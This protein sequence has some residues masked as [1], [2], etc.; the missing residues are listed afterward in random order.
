MPILV[1]TYDLEPGMKLSEAIVADGRIMLQG[2]KP[3]TDGDIRALRRRYPGMRMRVGDPVLDELI[4]FEDDSRERAVADDAQR[5]VAKCMKEVHERFSDRA[6]LSNVQVGALQ[7][8]VRDV[9]DFIK[10]NPVSMALLSTC[11]EPGSYLHLHAGNVFYLSMLL[12]FRLLDY[13]MSERRR[14]TRAQLKSRH[15]MDLVPLGFGAMVMDVGLSEHQKLLASEHPLTSEQSAALRRHPDEGLKLL[16]ERISALTRMVV[17]SHHENLCSNGYPK[18][19]PARKVHI[20]ARIVRIADAYDAVT[21]DRVFARAKSPA[22]AL[23]EMV[24]G[25]T[26]AYYDPRLVQAFASLIQ[27]FPIGAKLRLADGRYAVVV[28]YNRRDPFDPYVVIAFDARGRN[29][30]REQLDGP[31]RIATRADLALAGFGDEDLSFLQSRGPT[32]P[33]GGHEQFAYAIDAFYP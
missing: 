11:I 31:L 20:F 28:R 30:P 8:T 22:R 18:A 12:G 25:P 15:A 14:Q 9:M 16:P 4:E 5:Q 24:Y 26:A 23:W 13:V 6:S 19:A 10:S 27:P 32:P 7:S 33:Q 29:L 17:R 1:P 2:N 21:S 3:L